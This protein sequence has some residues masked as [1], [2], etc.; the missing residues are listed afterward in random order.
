MTGVRGN[1]G[2]Y[3]EASS[4]GSLVHGKPVFLFLNSNIC[5]KKEHKHGP[6]LHPQKARLGYLHRDLTPASQNRP[7]LRVADYNYYIMY[8][9]KKGMTT[10]RRNNL[11]LL[12]FSAFI[13]FM[14]T[15]ENCVDIGDG[16]AVFGS[17]TSCVYEGFDFTVFAFKTAALYIFGVIST[18]ILQMPEDYSSSR[19]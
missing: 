11:Y 2:L 4:L 5:N 6:L 14:M 10:K 19:S 15:G 7:K 9:M 17:G 1:S 13:I 16:D 8:Y 12:V 18:V 3:L